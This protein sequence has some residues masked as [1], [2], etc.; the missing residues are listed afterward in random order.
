MIEGLEAFY[1]SLYQSSIGRIMLRNKSP[2]ILITSNN[3]HLFGS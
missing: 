3:K 1:V 2:Q